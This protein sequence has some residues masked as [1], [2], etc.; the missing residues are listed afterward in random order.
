MTRG[1][2]IIAILA[3]AGTLAACEGMTDLERGAVGAGAGALAAEAVD[4][5]P[6]T[7]AAIGAGAGVFCDDAGICRRY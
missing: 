5:N 2:K 7:G 1:M 3:S 4:V 6:V